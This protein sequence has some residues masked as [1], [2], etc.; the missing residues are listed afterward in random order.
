[1][2]YIVEFPEGL[3]VI[4]STAEEVIALRRAAGA[5]GLSSEPTEEP[6]AISTNFAALRSWGKLCELVVEP[7]YALQHRILAAVK[8]HPKGISADDLMR[9]LSISEAGGFGARI[10]GV[11]RLG[12]AAGYQAHELLVPAGKSGQR[13]YLPGEALAQGNLPPVPE[14]GGKR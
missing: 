4:A 3:R 12:K 9:A 13:S 8:G 6:Q 5:V 11:G 2:P 10:A 7:K 14:P 1:M